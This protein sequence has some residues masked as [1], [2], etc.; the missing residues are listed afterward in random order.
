MG[1]RSL[2]INIPCLLR[3]RSTRVVFKNNDKEPKFQNELIFQEL[4]IESDSDSQ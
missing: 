1:A 2:D 3:L 4:L